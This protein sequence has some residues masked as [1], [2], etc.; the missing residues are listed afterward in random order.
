MCFHKFSIPSAIVKL[1][2]RSG[3]SRHYS[4]RGVV[5]NILSL[6][7][8]NLYYPVVQWYTVGLI[9]ILQF[10]IG[11]Q[12]QSIGFIN[13]FAQE[14]IPSGETVFIGITRDFKSGG[15]QCDVVLRLNKSLYSQ[16]K[17]THLWYEKFRKILLDRGVVVTK[18]DPCLLM[19]K[20]L[21]CVAYVYY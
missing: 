13:D 15:V 7:P 12:S 10:I 2:G 8:L 9:F 5:Q 11:L 4:V 17:A 18:V 14:D 21:I 1:I 20:T 19:S 16:A 6:E 3:S